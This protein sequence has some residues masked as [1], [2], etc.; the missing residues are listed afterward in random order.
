MFER[1][2][3]S[4]MYEAIVDQVRNAII[5]GKLVPGD[6]L[7]GDREL[8]DQFGAGRNTLREAIRTLEQMGLVEVKM[9]P[10]GGVFVTP[11]SYKGISNDIDLSIRTKQIPVRDLFEFRMLVE[12]PAATMAAR[13][14]SKSGVKGLEQILNQLEEVLKAPTSKGPSKWW[15]F[16]VLEAELHK[17]IA[18]LSGNVLIDKLLH[19]LDNNDYFN[20]IVSAKARDHMLQA[21]DDW[22]QIVDAIDRRDEET[23]S[24]LM[25]AHIEYFLSIQEQNEV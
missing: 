10:K 24:A 25:K 14:A 11:L 5:D 8:Q 13:N 12:V 19:T 23:V 3:Y 22:R 15:D 2:Q 4:R 17:Q 6:R 9:G 20:E 18:S 16:F 7:P 21:L 1:P